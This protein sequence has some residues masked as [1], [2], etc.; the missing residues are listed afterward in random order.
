MN[1]MIYFPII[2][3]FACSACSDA[4]EIQEFY[5]A[6]RSEDSSLLDAKLAQGVDVNNARLDGWRPL[7]FSVANRKAVSA[8]WLLEN[9]AGANSMDGGGNNAIFWAVKV[10]DERLITLLLHRRASPCQA[11]VNGETAMSMAAEYGNVALLKE[12]GRCQD[13]H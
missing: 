3:V 2:F 11:G 13:E 4:T 6:L 9:G 5:D 12:L 1:R 10:R 8:V 7:P